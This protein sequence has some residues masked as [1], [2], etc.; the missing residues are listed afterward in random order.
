MILFDLNERER[1]KS[2]NR[3]GGGRQGNKVEVGSKIERE[4]RKEGRK[5]MSRRRERE[6]CTRGNH[7]I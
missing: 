1:E 6:S 5:K 3:E 7:K 2:E 4:G